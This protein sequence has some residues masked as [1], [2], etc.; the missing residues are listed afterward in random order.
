MCLS[1]K[2]SSCFLLCGVLQGLGCVF[3]IAADSVVSVV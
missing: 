3:I 1:Q 2:P